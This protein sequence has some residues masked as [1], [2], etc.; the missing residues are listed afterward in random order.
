MER[1]A[2]SAATVFRKAEAPADTTDVKVMHDVSQLASRRSK[3]VDLDLDRLAADGYIMPNGTRSSLA[4]EMRVIKRPLLSNMQGKSAAPVSA[5]NLVMITS[6]LPGEGKTFMAI[7]LAFSI[8]MEVDTTVLLV[9]ADVARPALPS[10]LGLPPAK[11]LL[12]LLTNKDLDVAD[13]L[14][15]HEHRA[16]FD[17]AGRNAAQPRDGTSGQRRHGATGRRNWRVVTRTGS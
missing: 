12:D 8:A 6:S 16:A 17:P 3:H 14:S 5:A 10:R 7:N 11:G 4:D 1:E 15:A 9:D 13:V 2:G